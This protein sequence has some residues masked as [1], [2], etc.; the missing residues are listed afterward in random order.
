LKTADADYFDGRSAVSHRSTVTLDGNLLR[1]RFDG[2][3]L[4]YHRDQVRLS[5]AVGSIPRSLR[6][7]DGGICELHDK[8]FAACFEQKTGGSSISGCLHRLEISPTAVVASLLLCIMLVGG[9]ILYGLPWLAWRAAFSIPIVM[10]ERLDRESLELLDRMLVKPSTLP[11]EN[12]KR[13]SSSSNRCRQVFPL[14]STTGWSFVKAQ[15]WG[16]THWPCP[17]ARSF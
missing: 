2:R 8:S 11:T 4:Q 16:P 12:G 17:A 9:F 5:E 14:I 13:L 1:I 15:N 6:L 3:E 7:P 10:E